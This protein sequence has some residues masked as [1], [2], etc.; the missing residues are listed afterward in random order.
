MK[1][2][3]WESL[4]ADALPAAGRKIVGDTWLERM[5]QEHLAVGAFSLLAQELAQDGCDETVLSLVTRAANDEVRHTEVC[6]RMAVALLGKDAVPARVRGLPKVPV[7][8]GASPEVRVLLHLVEMC[9]LS[10][11]LTGVYFTEMLARARQ[12]AARAVLESLLQDEIDHG[13]V[14]WAYLA[15][16]ARDERLQGLTEALPAMLDRTVGRALRS[17]ERSPEDDGRMES[18]GWL[19]RTAAMAALRRAL[20]DVIVPGFETLGVD[21][22]AS[23]EAVDAFVG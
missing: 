1:P 11:T 7:H 12:P 10:E 18:Y 8:A 21:L 22:S 20:R 13:R 5:K 3:P 14:G 9:C 6:R 16:R 15:W 4:D 17:A 2:I 23:R 19:A